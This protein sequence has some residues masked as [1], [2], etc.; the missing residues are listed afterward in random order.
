LTGYQTRIMPLA[1]LRC[2]SHKLT[3]HHHHLG[4]VDGI[5]DGLRPV[6]TGVRSEIGSAN[7]NC[8]Q[9]SNP[10]Y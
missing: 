9:T 1:N 8:P 4:H 2:A 10:P 3:R 6:P 7:L 5:D